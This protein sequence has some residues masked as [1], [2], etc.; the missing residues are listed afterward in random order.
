MSGPENT[1][2]R[3]A[4][5]GAGKVGQ[6]VGVLLREAGFEIVA[7]TA[8]SNE[9]ARTAALTTGGEATADNARAASAADIVFV[10]ANDDAIAS[11]VA[12]VAARGGWRAGQVVVHTSGALGLDV[13]APAAGAG[14]L[15]ASIHPL[16]SF[17]SASDAVRELP[18]S[19][20]GVTAGPGAGETAEALVSAL[21]GTAV[22]VPEE[23]KA[24]YH[25]AAAVASNGLVAVEDV[26]VRM[27]ERAGF[28]RDEA[29]TALA[30]LLRGTAT[31]VIRLGPQAALTG[32]VS[33]GDAETV[34]RH[35]A[36]LADAP[37]EWREIYVA[38]GR[39]QLRI[40]VERGSVDAEAAAR[41]AAL[42]DGEA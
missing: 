39:Q 20:F 2:R 16:Q 32:P 41:I 4:V 35:L 36:A 27:L 33:R 1:H 34:A 11:L 7:V 42:L 15:V 17:A 24:L 14:A 30:P 31:N 13:L 19:V 9:H 21:G 18:G 28:G 6:A 29:V 25:A 22:N 8:R 23:A 5:L 26:A 10:T 40:A 3:V 12:D 37:P 38:L